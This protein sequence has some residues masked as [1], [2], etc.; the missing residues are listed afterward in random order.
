MYINYIIN[1]NYIIHIPIVYVMMRRCL[2]SL[3][4]ANKD[5]LIPDFVVEGSHDIDF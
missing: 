5:E 4:E 3:R 2:S 1:H